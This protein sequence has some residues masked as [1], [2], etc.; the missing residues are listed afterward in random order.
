MI[1]ERVVPVVI[2][3]ERAAKVC[4]KWGDD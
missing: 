2:E 3:W 1:S 4:I